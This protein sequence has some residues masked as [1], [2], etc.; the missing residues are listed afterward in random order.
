MTK[1]IKPTKKKKLVKKTK[2][3]VVEKKEETALDI[4][5]NVMNVEQPF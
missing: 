3:K 1:K 2:A 5:N 4:F